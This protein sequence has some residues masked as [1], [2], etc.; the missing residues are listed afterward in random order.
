MRVERWKWAGHVIRIF[1][2][3][4]PK[5][6]LEGSLGGRRPAGKPRNRYEDEVWKDATKLLNTKHLS[7]VVRHGSDW[8]KKS[9]G[10]G[11]EMSRRATGRKHNQLH[12]ICFGF[13]WMNGWG[14]NYL[15]DVEP[16]IKVICKIYKLA[17]FRLTDFWRKPLNS[18]CK[19]CIEVRTMPQW[20]LFLALCLDRGSTWFL[21]VIV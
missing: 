20:I 5:W 17:V 7:A 6:F 4:I 1:D 9:G 15:L 2:N 16:H 11:Q 19:I 3:R 12:V 21:S 8:R 18:K 10:L 13:T 14:I